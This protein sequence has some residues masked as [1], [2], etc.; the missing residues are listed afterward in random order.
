MSVLKNLV[1]GRENGIRSNLRKALGGGSSEDTSP[2]S[3]YSAPSNE[4]PP[5]AERALGL[6]PEAPK[7]VTPPEGYEVVL[8]KDALAPGNITEIIIAGQAIA[9]ANVD[10][11]FHA[12]SNTCLHAG[13]ALGDGDMDGSLV[14]CPLHGWQFDVATGAC[15]TNPDVSIQNYDV[16]IEKTAV[17]VKL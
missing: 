2:N 9:V 15:I 4:P 11:D 12:L 16:Q 10:G 5:P 3:S 1:F 13:G 17:C 7:D 8:H 6:Q 14:T